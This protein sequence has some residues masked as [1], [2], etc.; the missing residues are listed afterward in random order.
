M[1]KTQTPKRLWDYCI[2]LQAKIRSN[3]AHDIPTLGGQTPETLMG[4]ETANIS[5]LSEYDW[6]QW[7]YFRD[8]QSSF[9]D[10][11]KV[12]VRYM[13]PAKSN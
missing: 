7:L 5:E 1:L 6:F 10:A 8:T 4:G 13:G 2:E 12:L 11:T 3:T 9:P